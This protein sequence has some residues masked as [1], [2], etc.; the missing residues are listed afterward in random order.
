MTDEIEARIDAMKRYLDSKKARPEV[1]QIGLQLLLGAT[2]AV[3]RFGADSPSC[4]WR[5]ENAA[6]YW[7]GY[8][9]GQE[10]PRQRYDAY[11]VEDKKSAAAFAEMVIAEEKKLGIVREDH[12]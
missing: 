2:M 3:E 9:L 12:V 8:V 6:D 10:E 11:M 1:E 4:A 7:R 5:F